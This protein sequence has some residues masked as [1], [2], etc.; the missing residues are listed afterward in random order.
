[1]VPELPFN[2]RR[3]KVRDVL[4]NFREISLSQ[5]GRGNRR[6]YAIYVSLQESHIRLQFSSA[7]YVTVH[8]GPSFL[9]TD[10]MVDEIALLKCGSKFMLLVVNGSGM[11]VGSA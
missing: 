1:M 5:Q 10:L 8:L 11:L 3:L 6:D 9:R 7:A 2:L 4:P